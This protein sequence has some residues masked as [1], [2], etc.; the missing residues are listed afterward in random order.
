M[1]RKIGHTII[2]L[3]EVDSTNTYLKKNVELTEKHGLVVIAKMQTSGRGRAGRKF[4]SIPNNNLTFSVV[5]HPHLP[6]KDIQVFSLLAGIVVARVLENYIDGIK[7]KWPNDVLVNGKKICGIL[8]ETNFSIGQTYPSLIMGIGLNIKGLLKDYPNELQDILTTM[9]EE[10]LRNSYTNDKYQSRKLP[11]IEK[12]FQEILAE[13]ENCFH[14]FTGNFQKNINL[15]NTD[16]SRALL[17]QEWLERSKM[18]GKKVR[19][20]DVSRKKSKLSDTIGTLKRLTKEGFLII[21]TQSGEEMMH[22]SGD[23][24]ELKGEENDSGSRH[25]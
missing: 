8:I 7:L 4:I 1:Y 16:M 12:I 21:K 20:L 14:K 19:I 5:L 11:K 25:R 2:R 17:I 23:V 22:V 10:I 6:S 18:L 13:L 9:E 3:D 24:I 15:K